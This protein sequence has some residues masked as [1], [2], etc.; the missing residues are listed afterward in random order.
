MDV[1]TTITALIASIGASLSARRTAAAHVGFN[2]FT[3]LLAFSLL[4]LYLAVVG[5]L[6][7]GGGGGDLPFLLTLFHTGF[8]LLGI[9]LMLPLTHPFARLIRLLVKAR[10]ERPADRLE[11]LPEQDE[12]AEALERAGAALRQI[13]LDLIDHIQAVL[14]RS[15]SS[16]RRRTV[17][18][19]TLQA[20]LDR[21]ELYL[22]AIHLDQLDPSAGHR[23]LHLLHALDHLQRLHERC[24]EERDR[25]ETVARA[26]VLAAERD[27]LAEGV[28]GLE[29]WV[30]TDQWHAAELAA[31]ALAREL[32]QRVT[33]FR[34]E[35]MELEASGAVDTER[36]T[37]LL[38]AMRWLRR[39][40]QHLRQ[41]CRHLE[42]G[43]A[44]GSAHQRRDSTGVPVA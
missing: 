40:S 16:A 6:L 32:H 17:P 34:R 33:P 14:G 11:R 10:Q 3:A 37:G 28:T 30:C 38:E 5:R 4:P 27:S 18:L 22:D 43:L 31:A 8:N 20:D 19:K 44:V 25:G 39:V 26:D 2:C 24:E 15:G 13:F 7:P 42:A 21:I 29:E 35:V 36:G 41:I 1:G 23:L 12:A 9:A